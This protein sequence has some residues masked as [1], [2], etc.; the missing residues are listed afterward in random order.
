VAIRDGRFD[1]VIA[2][3]AGAEPTKLS[4]P[5]LTGLAQFGKGQLEPAAA[6]FRSAL[7]VSNEFLPAVFYLG[8]CYAAGGRDRE[9]V[10]AWLTS[11]VTES[12]ARIVFDVLADALLRLR[13]GEQALSI[14]TEARDRWPDDDAFV[15]RLAAAQA[16]LQRRDQAIDILVPYIE[17]HPGDTAAIVLAVRLLYDAH[18]SGAAA[19]TPARDRELAARFAALY[20]AASGPHAALVDRWAAFVQ[21]SRVER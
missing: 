11:L 7:R 3:L 2:A 13:D 10:G 1:D 14:L 6:Q 16:L 15:P 12:E 17:R 20:R 5:F 9:A 21:Q 4:V 19:T 8:A 18:A